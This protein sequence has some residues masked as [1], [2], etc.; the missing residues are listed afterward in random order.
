VA[1]HQALFSPRSHFPPFFPSFAEEKGV[2]SGPRLWLSSFL[3]R[4]FR[5][6]CGFPSLCGIRFR[7]LSEDIVSRP[8]VIRGREEI[9]P[10]TNP[11]FESSANPL[12]LPLLCYCLPPPPGLRGNDVSSARIGAF[13]SPPSPKTN[14]RPFPPY[15]A[16]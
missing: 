4:S 15:P 6:G 5:E 11:D 7:Y 8:P 13:A 16:S 12:P 3:L 10:S 14:A 9:S 1:P 2:R